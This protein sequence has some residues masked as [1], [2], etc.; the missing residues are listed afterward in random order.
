[1]SSKR[2]SRRV[3]LQTAAATA[4]AAPGKPIRVG[5]IGAGS[6]GLGMLGR[7]L[8]HP[9]VRIAAV[10]DIVEQRATQAQNRVEKATGERPA[11][12]TRG[13]EDWKRLLDRAD[14]DA[15]LIMTPQDQHGPQAI[16]AMRAGKHVGSETPSGYTVDELWELVE[17]KQKTGRRYML[18]ENYPYA[19]P[20]MAVLHMAHRGVFGDL[21]YG[22]SSYVH[23]TRGL[24][25]EK[26]GALSWRG[27]IARDH[28]G[29]LYPTH[30][31]GPVCLWMGIHR[32]DRLVT[33]VTMDSGTENLRAYARE[34]FGKEHPAARPGFFE[35]RDTTVTMIRTERERL[36]VLKYATTSPRP[37]G[38]WALLEGTRGA[39]DSSPGGEFVHL[40][41]RSP[42]EKWEPLEKYYAAYDHPWW[43]K[44][45]AE[46]IKEGHGGG[47]FFVLREFY[48]SLAEDREPPIDVYDGAAWSAILPLS[49]ESIRT[50]NRPVE[51]PDF[52]RGGWKSRRLEGWGLL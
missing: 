25:Y 16:A 8:V 23:D 6:R 1:M 5:L 34:Q 27:R 19:R 26:D 44:D 48:R 3:F 46:A 14:I 38:G 50:G 45:G 49:A 29:D 2:P 10:C 15:V 22:E 32:G 17:T 36:I 21:T 43:S 51:I 18:L 30:G 13:P 31:L 52:T 33:M 4:I 41:G 24:A 37:F 11:P 7:S 12:Y 20:R 28:R 47:D 39:Y 40:A 35:K 42:A 9:G